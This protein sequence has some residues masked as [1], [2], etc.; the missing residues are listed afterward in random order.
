MRSGYSVK[1]ASSRIAV[2]NAPSQSATTSPSYFVEGGT[3]TIGPESYEISFNLS[4]TYPTLST[5]VVGDA[6]RGQLDSTYVLA[7]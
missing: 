2:T 7:L 3:E 5:F 1:L 6:T 4:P